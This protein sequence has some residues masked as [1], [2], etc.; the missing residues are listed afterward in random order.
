M[1]TLCA[2]QFVVTQPIRH[3]VRQCGVDSSLGG[4]RRQE[5]TAL[6]SA[7]LPGPHVVPFLFPI[8]S[9]PIPSIIHS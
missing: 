6:H 8:P 3:D 2:V 9:H 7:A 5:V 4:L 1:G